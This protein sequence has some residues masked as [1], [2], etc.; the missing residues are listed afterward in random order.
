MEIMTSESTAASSS[1]AVLEPG[2]FYPRAR[3]TAMNVVTAA[4]S[5]PKPSSAPIYAVLLYGKGNVA[6]RPNYL[7]AVRTFLMAYRKGFKALSE[8]RELKLSHPDQDHVSSLKTINFGD[9]SFFWGT[10]SATEMRKMVD[11]RP[12]IYIFP[13]HLDHKLLL[14]LDLPSLPEPFAELPTLVQVHYPEWG[15]LQMGSSEVLKVPHHGRTESF[16]DKKTLEWRKQFITENPFFTSDEIA[17]EA[18]SRA[19]NRAAMASRWVQEKKIFSIRF[20]GQQLFPRFQFEDGRPIPAVSEV[21]RTFPEHA[22]GWELAY[23][24]VSPNPNIG[25]SKPVELLKR[26]PA[27]LI[28]LAHAFVHPAD[29]F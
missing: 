28:S 11:P 20:Q 9:V 8:H 19:T 29:V 24:F 23:F 21:I 3:E 4:L 26:D 22:T 5:H 27:R 1:A 18:T 6:K 16:A 14:D 17:Q 13:L 15:D 7:T 10:A 12:G 25:G 2:G